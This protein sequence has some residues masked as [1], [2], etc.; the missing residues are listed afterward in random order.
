MQ[1]HTSVI[2]LIPVIL[3]LYLVRQER[4]R[5]LSYLSVGKA[6]VALG[7]M[8]RWKALYLFKRG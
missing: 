4:C 1:L 7:P 2:F 6:R 3:V 8:A 5:P